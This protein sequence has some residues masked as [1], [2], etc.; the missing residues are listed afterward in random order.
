MVG[1]AEELRYLSFGRVASQAIE[2]YGSGVEGAGRERGSQGRG[3]NTEGGHHDEDR[4]WGWDY[5]REELR[6]VD[7]SKV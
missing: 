4:G 5:C 3:S 2:G 7:E 1:R 6:V